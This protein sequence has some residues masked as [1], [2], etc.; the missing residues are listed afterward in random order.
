MIRTART[1][2]QDDRPPPID[3]AL[4]EHHEH[5]PG[6]EHES[7]RAKRLLGAS[8]EPE[9]D[10]PEDAADVADGER[11]VDDKDASLAVTHLR[12]RQLEAQHVP[13]DP[14]AKVFQR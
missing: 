10:E 3:D 1:N 6:G 2:R 9:R 7:E 5:E 8:D 11:A 13:A 4:T 12:L 14:P